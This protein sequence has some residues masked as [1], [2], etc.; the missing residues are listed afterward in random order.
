VL[1]HQVHAA[2]RLIVQC[3]S[4]HW[5][6]VAA[7]CHRVKAAAVH[8]PRV[9]RQSFTLQLACSCLGACG[10]RVCLASCVHACSMQCAA[11]YQRGQG[12]LPS[13]EVAGSC[14]HTCQVCCDARQRLL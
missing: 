3:V 9:A 8:L 10:M 12:N 7:V 13:C 4:K 6:S 2:G 14:T 1:K 5:R 11:G